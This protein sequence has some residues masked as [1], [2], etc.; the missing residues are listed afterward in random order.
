MTRRAPDALPLPGRLLLVVLLVLLV[1]GL[2]DPALFARP[3]CVITGQAASGCCAPISQ[4]S[5][6]S[7][8]QGQGEADCPCC[9]LPALVLRP[10]ASSEKQETRLSCL[11]WPSVLPHVLSPRDGQRPAMLA[12]L[13]P[14][15]RQRP[16][17]SL[18]GAWL[19]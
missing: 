12:G 19:R 5:Q 2:T 6:D 9:E 4:S 15:P 1:L 11:C 16:I 18:H 13:D 3:L 10:E 8:L 7:S 17:Y 14:P